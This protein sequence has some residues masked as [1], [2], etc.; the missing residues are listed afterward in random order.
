M[1]ATEIAQKAVRLPL[2]DRKRVIARLVMAN[3]R[4]EREEWD[5]LQ[6]RMDDRDPKN[7]VSLDEVKAKLLAPG[8]D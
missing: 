1:N 2:A 7:W 4:D 8:L 5:E 6:R 3:M